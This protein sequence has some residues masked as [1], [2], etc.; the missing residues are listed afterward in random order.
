[1]Q[2]KTLGLIGNSG[3]SRQVAAIAKAFGM[4]VLMYS[5]YPEPENY[6]F[7]DLLNLAAQSDF[8]SVHSRLDSQT[9]GLLGAKFFATMRPTS[10]LI[11]TGRAAI[12]D[13]QAFLEALRNKKIAGAAFDVFWQEPLPLDHPIFQFNNVILTPHMAW[14]SAETRQK[15]IGTLAEVIARFF[16]GNPIH[17][18]DPAHS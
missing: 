11:N 7:V 3:I 4:K 17:L 18:V 1:M 9:R 13:E 6:E 16:A 5:R 14:G 15:M 2:G 12:I 8:V 10:Y